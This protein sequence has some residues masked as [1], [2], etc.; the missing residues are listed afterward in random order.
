R[1]RRAGASSPVGPSSRRPRVARRSTCPER[2]RADGPETNEAGAA[3]RDARPVARSGDGL[4]VAHSPNDSRHSTNS[5]VCSQPHAPSGPKFPQLVSD[6]QVYQGEK[7]QI[8]TSGPSGPTHSSPLHPATWQ[9]STGSG[10][11]AH[12]QTS[13]PVSLSLAKPFSQN[14]SQST[15]S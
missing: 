14:S 4:C 5:G 10:S 2:D 1:S 13:Q 15:G 9:S 3:T 12:S 7:M 8:D 11:E 6:R